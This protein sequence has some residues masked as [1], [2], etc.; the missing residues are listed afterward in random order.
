MV[1][2]QGSIRVVTAPPIA[3]WL[4]RCVYRRMSITFLLLTNQ[5]PNGKCSGLRDFKG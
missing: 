4:C 2:W 5:L 1:M 3:V